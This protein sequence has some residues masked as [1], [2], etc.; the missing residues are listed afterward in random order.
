MRLPL[1]A[2]RLEPT[3]PVVGTQRH[4]EHVAQLAIEVGQVALW[5]LMAPTIG[6]W[7]MTT[8][9]A[10]VLGPI[11]GGYLCDEYSWPWIFLINV[12]TAA[13]CAFMGWRLLKRYEGALLRNPIDVVGLMLLDW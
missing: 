2:Q 11:L 1:F 6:L 5:W 13:A 3:P 4:T 8:L 9:V 10:P 7:S 12:P